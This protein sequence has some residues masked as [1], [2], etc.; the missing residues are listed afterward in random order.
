MNVKTFS[1]AVIAIGAIALVAIPVS[2]A[3]AQTLPAS[4]QVVKQVPATANKQL[5]AMSAK[6]NKPVP[7]FKVPV[8]QRQVFSPQARRNIRLAPNAVPVRN[9]PVPAANN[10]TRPTL[11]ASGGFRRYTPPTI[12][13]RYPATSRALP[14]AGTPAPSNGQAASLTSSSGAIGNRIGIAVRPNLSQPVFLIFST[15]GFVPANITSRVLQDS[16]GFYTP[17]P[18]Q[19]CFNNVQNWVAKLQLADGT[20]LDPIGRFAR[21]SNCP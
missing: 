3:L 5:P 1:N 10:S 6:S 15:G 18:A 8:T 14:A 11:P 17:V 19:L 2:N 16:R 12:G 13:N 20:L 4:R 9:A 7:A 21:P